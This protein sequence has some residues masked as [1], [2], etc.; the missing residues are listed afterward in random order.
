MRSPEYDNPMVADAGT[1]IFTIRAG[2]LDKTVN[3]YALGLDDPNI[4]T[5]QLAPHSR[6]CPSD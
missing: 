6:S 5:G 4:R 1:A 3:V 2:G